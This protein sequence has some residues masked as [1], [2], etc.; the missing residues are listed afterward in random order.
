MKRKRRIWR[1][2]F[3]I[4]L[5]PF[6]CLLVLQYAQ[7]GINVQILN[8]FSDEIQEWENKGY[9]L[10]EVVITDLMC[11]QEEYIISIFSPIETDILAGKPYYGIL[12]IYV[13]KEDEIVPFFE[14]E[15]DYRLFDLEVRDIDDDF[16]N[17]II[18]EWSTGGNSWIVNGIA[19][20][21]MRDGCIIPVKVIPPI[22]SRLIN[23]DDFEIHWSKGLIPTAYLADLDGDRV[24]ELLVLDTTFEN[25]YGEPVAWK[26]FSWRNGSY[27]EDCSSF[28]F[29]YEKKIDELKKELTLEPPSPSSSGEYSLRKPISLY[30][31]Y[32]YKGEAE[33]GFR[34]LAKL[35]LNEEFMA[36]WEAERKRWKSLSFSLK[37]LSDI[38]E[39]LLS[40][41]PL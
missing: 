24:C 9:E 16:N 8:S 4:L 25:F 2:F 23:H 26:V 14:K 17:E 13:V 20:F 29:Y 28:P 12:K 35:I 39:S 38:V 5:I 10:D 11:L 7:A 19:I 36:S 30:L 18:V 21:E 15:F 6:G 22:I 41:Y 40:K 27:Q 3:L 31:N 1:Y 34:E 32:Y 37:S 33:K